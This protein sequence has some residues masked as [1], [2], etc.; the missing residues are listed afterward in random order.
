[1]IELNFIQKELENKQSIRNFKYIHV[2]S[3]SDFNEER[4]IVLHSFEF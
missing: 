1:M 4:D 3:K 2:G